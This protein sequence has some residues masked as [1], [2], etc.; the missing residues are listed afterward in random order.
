MAIIWHV[1]DLQISHRDEWEI[2]KII[3]WLG[4]E[5]NNIKAKRRKNIIILE[6]IQTLNVK[7]Q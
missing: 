4:K 6:W 7:E 1:D 3:K 5:Y 2:A